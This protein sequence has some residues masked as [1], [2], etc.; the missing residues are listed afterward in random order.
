MEWF[1]IPDKNEPEKVYLRRLRILETPWFGVYLHWI[2]LPDTDRDPH[3]HPWKFASVILRGGYT[4]RVWRD[5]S[6][7]DH[8]TTRTWGP[9]SAHRMP[10]DWA[11]KI[12]ALG[13]NTI[14]LIFRGR[15][16]K[17]WGFWT[18]HG[19]VEW[20]DYVGESGPDPW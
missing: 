15:R 3:D 7:L 2:Y 12:E 6:H 14:T 20:R 10:L 17:S 9:W 1:A 16:S 5:L 4:E 11:H 18:D 19:V 13:P 8:A